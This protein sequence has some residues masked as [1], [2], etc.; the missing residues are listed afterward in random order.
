MKEP[1]D[2][3]K[4]QRD[5]LHYWAKRGKLINVGFQVLIEESMKTMAI[6]IT[7]GW[8]KPLTLKPR[9]FFFAGAGFLFSFMLLLDEG[10]IETDNDMEMMTEI[11]NELEEFDN[12]LRLMLTPKPKGKSS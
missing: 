4:E 11:Y 6:E 7:N 5:R 12:K 1:K 9:D 8:D 2:F 10:L 3:T